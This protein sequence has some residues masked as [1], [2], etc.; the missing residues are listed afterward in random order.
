MRAAG[1]RS[2][3]LLAAVDMLKHGSGGIRET[4]R[5]L[6]GRR[7]DETAELRCRVDAPPRRPREMTVA[8]NLVAH[9][10]RCDGGT[11]PYGYW[12]FLRHA[13]QRMERAHDYYTLVRDGKLLVACSVGARP[14]GGMLLS[15]LYVHR[16]ERAD[17]NVRNFLEQV[18]YD[19]QRQGREG[20]LCCSCKL[21]TDLHRAFVD[22]GFADASKEA[23]GLAHPFRT[24]QLWEPGP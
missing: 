11:A 4:V 23:T 8:R 19:L 13:M 17:E 2:A 5:A 24:P 3:D 12:G 9:L 22:S 7:G 20:F 18:L 15:D 1:Y 21:E 14:D 16:G 10:L 6:H